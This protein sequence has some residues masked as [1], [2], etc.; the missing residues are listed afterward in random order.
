LAKPNGL[1]DVEGP[2][3][4]TATGEDDFS[5]PNVNLNATPKNTAATPGKGGGQQQNRL[6]AMLKM[7][8]PVVTG[9]T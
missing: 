4:A 6:A 7:K 1:V 2:A 9:A 5:G 3:D 8:K